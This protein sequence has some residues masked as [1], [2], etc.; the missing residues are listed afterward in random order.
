M[1]PD[2]L[3]T[4]LPVAQRISNEAARLPTDLAST[5][6]VLRIR[7]ETAHCGTPS[8][9]DL[10]AM[11]SATDRDSRCNRQSRRSEQ[12]TTATVR[13]SRASEALGPTRNR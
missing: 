12:R 9:L 3:L 11:R 13:I 6:Q 8:N 4:M 5:N 10:A 1:S 2:I 7:D